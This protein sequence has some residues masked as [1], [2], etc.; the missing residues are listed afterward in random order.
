MS[1]KD[2][3]GKSTL[4][5]MRDYIKVSQEL[6]RYQGVKPEARK[7]WWEKRWVKWKKQSLYRINREIPLVL[8][9]RYEGVL[10]QLLRQ[11]GV[12]ST[13]LK[14]SVSAIW[15]SCQDKILTLDNYKRFSKVLWES[16]SSIID[17]EADMLKPKFMLR[18]FVDEMPS[19][20][21]RG[22]LLDRAYDKTAINHESGTEVLNKLTNAYPILHQQLLRHGNDLR[23][24]TDGE[25]TLVMVKSIKPPFV[26]YEKWLF[27]N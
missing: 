7:H 14:T 1:R 19:S 22:I 6:R 13:A 15:V 25:I 18:Q 4:T 3:Q 16:Y 8:T 17:E 9:A 26:Q 27:P 11:S 24:L 20:D 12:D 21:E 23:D 2:V 10:Y 5:L